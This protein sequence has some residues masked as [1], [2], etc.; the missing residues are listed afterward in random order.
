[1]ESGRITPDH[2]VATTHADLLGAEDERYDLVERVAAITPALRALSPRERVIVH[3]RFFEDLTQAEIA[4]ELGLSQ[5]H[6][7]RLLRRSLVRLRAVAEAKLGEE[8]P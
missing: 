1:M 4:Q 3:L 7:S 6:V 2:D 5:M 8:G